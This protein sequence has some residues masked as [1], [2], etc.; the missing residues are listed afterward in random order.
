MDPLGSP[1]A[2]S[3]LGV[4]AADATG[5]DDSADGAAFPQ[6]AVSSPITDNAA[7]ST[8]MV[9]TVADSPVPRGHFE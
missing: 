2:L 3:A 1:A 4:G 8:R 9:D 5:V 6:P 7:T